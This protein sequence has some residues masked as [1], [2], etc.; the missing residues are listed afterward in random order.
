[1]FFGILG[2]IYMYFGLIEKSE[3]KIIK[4]E[5]PIKVIG[6]S[7]KTSMKTIYKDSVTLGNQY[8][9]V[10]QQNLIQNKKE[11]WSFVVIS[12]NFSNSNSCWEYLM[13][14]IVTS[15]DNNPENLERFEIPVNTYAV[16]T[17]CPKFSFLW[18]PVIGFT[19]KYIFT[20]WLPSSKYNA[21]NNIIGDFEYHNEHSI[22]KKPSIDLYVPV[23]E[24][25]IKEN[26]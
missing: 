2:G 15:F 22:S 6:I 16:F 25:N 4:I 3:P 10:K 23:K 7:M 26:C 18:G 17:I 1:M 21:N 8:E 14:D 12:K 19:K 11:P 20:E 13:G 9:K 24:K 5:A